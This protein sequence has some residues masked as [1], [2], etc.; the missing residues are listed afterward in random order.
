MGYRALQ[1]QYTQR[2]L[3]YLSTPTISHRD[4]TDFIPETI[5]VS[6]VENLCKELFIAQSSEQPLN[7]S[8]CVM[9]LKMACRQLRVA[10]KL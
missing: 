9:A 8:L 6:R 10:V 4:I 1:K 5:C 2:T 3:V 7:Q